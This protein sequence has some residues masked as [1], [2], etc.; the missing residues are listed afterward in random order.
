MQGIC[1]SSQL[2]QTSP[3]ASHLIF[4]FLQLS[5]ALVTLCRSL[6][7]LAERLSSLPDMVSDRT[8]ASSTEFEGNVVIVESEITNAKK[9]KEEKEK[10]EENAHWNR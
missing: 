10:K 6:C 8:T 7:S 3:L 5:Q 2:E 4:F 9:Q 1:S